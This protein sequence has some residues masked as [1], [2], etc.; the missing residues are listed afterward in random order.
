MAGNVD[1]ID[2]EY[3]RSE[4][5][6]HVDGD[7][8]RYVGEADYFSKR[9]LFSGARCLLAPITWSEPFGLFMIEAMACG[10]PVVAFNRGS[11]PEVVKHGETGFVVDTLAEMVEAVHR[12]DQIT[13]QR[14]REHVE[15][16]F[17]VPRMVEGYLRAYQQVLEMESE[18]VGA[19]PVAPL[20]GTVLYAGP[21]MGHAKGGHFPAALPGRNQAPKA[22][23]KRGWHS[24]RHIG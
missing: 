16:N 9:K 23:G 4:V 10:T 20:A 14:C 8:V 7:Q 15:Q 17:D 5:L 18:K 24:L 22:A 6:P 2:R 13:R 19:I 21:D 12:V 11:T 1:T 3:F